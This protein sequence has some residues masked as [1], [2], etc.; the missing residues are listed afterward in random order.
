[1]LT[2]PD[3]LRDGLDIVFV[4][5]NP[6]WR[7]A[8]EGHY[9]ATPRNRFWPAFNAAGLAPA[10]LGPETDF[11]A[12]RYGI[13]FTDVVK[14]ATR[15]MKEL[16]A[17]E[18]REGAGALRDKLLRRQPLVVCFNGLSGYRNY[19][20]FTEGGAGDIELGLQPRDIGRSKVF[21]IPST[22]PANA[23][24]SLERIVDSLRQLKG[25]VAALKGR[26]G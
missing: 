15:Q 21:V 26:H 8:Q 1:M 6:G 22:S 14:R 9:F 16:K 20:R 25:A 19:L 7:S 18:F 2:L 11:Q 10:S 17:A 23:A 12:L 24:V 13:G 4:G 5:I 3:Y